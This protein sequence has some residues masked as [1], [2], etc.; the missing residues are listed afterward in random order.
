MA[1]LNE[2]PGVA[3]TGAVNRQYPFAQQAMHAALQCCDLTVIDQFGHLGRRG[4]RK[5][6]DV[7]EQGIGDRFTGEVRSLYEA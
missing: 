1:T 5:R 4:L 7:L 2:R 6:S 3:H